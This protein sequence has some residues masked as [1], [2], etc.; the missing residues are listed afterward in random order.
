MELFKSFQK[1]KK[2]YS[3]HPKVQTPLNFFLQ[4]SI[5]IYLVYDPTKSTNC[6]F[7]TQNRYK[8]LE[9]CSISFHLNS[10]TIKLSF[11]FQTNLTQSFF[12]L[13]SPIFIIETSSESFEM[14]FLASWTTFLLWLRS[15]WKSFWYVAIV[16]HPLAFHTLSHA[17][18]QAT[19]IMNWILCGR[20]IKSTIS[21][22]HMACN[23]ASMNSSYRA[24]VRTF[25]T[26]LAVLVLNNIVRILHD[27]KKRHFH[28]HQKVGHRDGFEVVK[29]QKI[30]RA[31]N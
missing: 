12:L 30:L 22:S 21:S 1:L 26:W 3:D 17:V 24:I 15:W 8:K 5:V 10:H 2:K 11:L 25:S 7:H 16:W 20:R 19:A 13:I 27:V 28:Q 31:I 18:A 6:Q 9:N 29:R 14:V 4:F 23:L